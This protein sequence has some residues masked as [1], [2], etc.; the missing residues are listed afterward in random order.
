MLLLFS[1]NACRYTI[2][3]GYN[4]VQ[5][6]PL[7]SFMEY[8]FLVVQDIFLLIVIFHIV[9]VLDTLK[10]G[11]VGIYIALFYGFTQGIP[12]PNVLPFLMV[13]IWKNYIMQ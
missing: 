3:L 8:V 1:M 6:Y 13:H 9:G 5:G 2:V 4:V 12:H 10:L 7:A 11:L